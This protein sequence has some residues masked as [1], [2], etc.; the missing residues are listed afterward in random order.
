MSLTKW[1]L[2]GIVVLAIFYYVSPDKFMETK[3]TTFSFVKE[4]IG[5][6]SEDTSTTKYASNGEPIA[7]NSPRVLGQPYEKLDVFCITNTQCEES[8]PDYPGVFCN[9]DTGECEAP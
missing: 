3:N 2:I 8:Y 7:S 6:T 1:I 4:K 5:G 9:H